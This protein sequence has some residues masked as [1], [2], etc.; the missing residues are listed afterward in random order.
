LQILH[1]LLVL[2]KLLVELGALLLGLLNVALSDRD[3]SFVL[4]LNSALD[5]LVQDIV[6]W[7]IA[8]HVGRWLHTI[9]K[10]VKLFASDSTVLILVWNRPVHWVKDD[11]LGGEFHE[12][13][14]LSHHGDELSRFLKGLR[15][16][17]INN[18]FIH[19]LLDLWINLSIQDLLQV[20]LGDININ[21][22][23]LLLLTL[24]QDWLYGI[25]ERWHISADIQNLLDRLQDL[26]ALHFFELCLGNWNN[27]SNIATIGK[28][29][30]DD[31]VVDALSELS[32]G[33]SHTWQ[34]SEDLFTID[35]KMWDESLLLLIVAY[36]ELILKSLLL[37]H[38]FEVRGLLDVV[39]RLLLHHSGAISRWNLKLVL[40]LLSLQ[41]IWSVNK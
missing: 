2:A 20:V 6:H 15:Q 1:D 7:N 22:I 3:A 19:S 13:L 5:T 14:F 27:E 9:N 4:F 12:E 39:L 36:T 29:H 33:F 11:E 35:G 21:S 23:L 8:D 31:K 32:I 18:D 17:T 40:D 24:E 25:D 38:V 41:R 30:L 37:E 26:L 10:F 28:E 16:L 34:V